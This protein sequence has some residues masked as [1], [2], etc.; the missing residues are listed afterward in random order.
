MRILLCRVSECALPLGF[1]RAQGIVQRPPASQASVHEVMF[2]PHAVGDALDRRA[3]LAPRRQLFRPR[4]PS[5]IRRFV[6]TCGID[7]VNRVRVARAH[8]HV[9]HKRI[10]ARHPAIAYANASTSV[11]HP[12]WLPRVGASRLHRAPDAVC[13]GMRQAVPGAARDHDV[14]FQTS[15]A[16]RAPI[17][18][19]VPGCAVRPSARALAYPRPF[20][21]N[22]DVPADHCQPAEL[23]ASQIEE[24]GH[25]LF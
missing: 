4:R 13:A 14:K 1:R 18:Q 24:C 10:E 19:V 9:G 2:D 12:R 22:A 20:A 16:S 11:A 6:V 21:R 8:A 3:L 25:V 23:P 17:A 7:P 5:A 15:A